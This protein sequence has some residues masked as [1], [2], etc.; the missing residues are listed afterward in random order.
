MVKEQL[1]YIPAAPPEIIVRKLTKENI[2]A[3]INSYLEDNGYWFKLYYLAGESY[4][5][6]DQ[7]EMDRMIEEIK[8]WQKEV[9][10]SE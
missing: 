8:E 7:N 3:A 1:D 6:F 4:G 9:M 10:E 5:V 2:E